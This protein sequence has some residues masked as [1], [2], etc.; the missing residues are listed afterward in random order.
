[1]GSSGMRGLR[2][3]RGGNESQ[4]FFAKFAERGGRRGSGAPVTPN[5]DAEGCEIAF[6]CCPRDVKKQ[7]A[8]HPFA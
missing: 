5:D 6:S 4:L 1:M 7:V 8:S 3:R 2:R